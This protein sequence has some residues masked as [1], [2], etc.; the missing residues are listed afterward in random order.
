MEGNG[1]H[2]VNKSPSKIHSPHAVPVPDRRQDWEGATVALRTTHTHRTGKH[3]M[4]VRPTSLRV[5]RVACACRV[6]VRCR[7][8]GL[9]F[10]AEGKKLPKKRRVFE[11]NKRA[12]A[13]HKGDAGP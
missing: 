11:R 12:C 8:A 1:D 7:T 6:W 5:P 4:Q 9:A 2:G 3:A 10:S 13:W